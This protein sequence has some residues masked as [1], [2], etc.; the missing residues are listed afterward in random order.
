MDFSGYDCADIFHTVSVSSSFHRILANSQTAAA[1]S[2]ENE[3]MEDMI[4]AGGGFEETIAGDAPLWAL[5]CGNLAALATTCIRLSPIPTVRDFIKK[6]HTG[7]LP[8]VPYTALL[9]DSL[10]WLTFGLMTEDARIVIT[11]IF[12][13]TL[14]ALYALAYARTW[15]RSGRPQDSAIIG[16]GTLEQ[17]GM[18]VICIVLFCFFVP[19]VFPAESARK[20]VA[21]AAVSGSLAMYAG[22]LAAVQNVLKEKDASSIPIP[23]ATCCMVNAFFWIIYGWVVV[24]EPALW[25]PSMVGFVFSSIQFGLIFKYGQKK[26]RPLRRNDGGGGVGS[27]DHGGD[28]ERLSDA[29]FHGSLDSIVDFDREVIKQLELNEI[30]EGLH[31]QNE[32][33]A[34]FLLQSGSTGSPMSKR[35]IAAAEY[36]NKA[37]LE[38]V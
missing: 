10:C 8:I 33:D 27:S 14:S 7:S 37:K 13:T 3:F 5:W 38:L 15:I 36:S 22:P 26:G 12:G 24:D 30:V 28:Y 17:H 1:S 25:A 6:R 32:E 16:F 19:I 9:A 21:L 11:H 2:T 31:L 18:A 23:Y 20:I 34:T 35:P 4:T 29:S